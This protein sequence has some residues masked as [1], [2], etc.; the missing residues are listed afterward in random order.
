MWAEPGGAFYALLDAP[1]TVAGEALVKRLVLEHGVAVLCGES[2][3]LDPGQSGGP[4]LRLS[5]G[6]LQEPELEQALARLFAGISA[7]LDGGAPG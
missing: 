7:L 5:Y 2:F 3:G 4:V 1:A 6:L